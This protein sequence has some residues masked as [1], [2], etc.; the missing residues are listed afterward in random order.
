[1]G[2]YSGYVFREGACVPLITD[3]ERSQPHIGI[4]FNFDYLEVHLQKLLPSRF[5]LQDMNFGSDV[6]MCLYLFI[7]G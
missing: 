3:T 6:M 2:S 4:F 7:W 1:M 5:G